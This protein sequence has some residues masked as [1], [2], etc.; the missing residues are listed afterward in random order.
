VYE[1]GYNAKVLDY[2]KSRVSCDLK[3]QR[4]A[5]R[6]PSSLHMPVGFTC[7]GSCYGGGS[8]ERGRMDWPYIY[9]I[10]ARTDEYSIGSDIA[11]GQSE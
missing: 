6:S 9:N 10:P 11:G 2:G 8:K 3:R 5:A 4:A 7:S 1:R